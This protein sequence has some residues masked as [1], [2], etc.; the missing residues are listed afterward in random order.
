MHLLGFQENLERF[1]SSASLVVVPLRVGTGTR[2][3]ILEAF[4]HGCPVVSTSIGAMGLKVT[5]E[6]NIFLADQPK[7][8]AHAC[9]KILKTPHLASR[10][11]SE[12]QRLH[13]EY[14][15]PEI[16]DQFYKVNLAHVENSVLK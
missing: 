11:I 8:F 6:K 15:S 3:K 5:H 9:L 7:L 14:Y 16:L 1:Y 10:L 2:V 4:V 12:G 13:R